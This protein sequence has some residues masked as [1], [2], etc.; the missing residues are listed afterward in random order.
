MIERP[1]FGERLMKR[2]LTAILIWGCATTAFADPR[3][4]PPTIQKTS[5]P[6]VT[7]GLAAEVKVE[8]INLVGTTEV[9]FDD[10][11]IKGRLLHVNALGEFIGKFVG[12]NGLRSTVNR[13]DPPPL[14]EVTIEVKADSDAKLG[15]YRFRLV[16]NAGT[17]NTGIVSVEPFY[18]ARPEIEPNDTLQEARCRWTTFSR[19][20]SSPAGS[21]SRATWIICVS[22]R[23]P[24]T[25]S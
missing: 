23:P 13:G 7:R 12:S 22:T 15:L 10:P 14:N 11:A 17:T 25:N 16:T 4:N 8:G 6:A 20:P 5:P 19:R 3:I 2:L 1:P 18:G 21:A 24:A 9:L